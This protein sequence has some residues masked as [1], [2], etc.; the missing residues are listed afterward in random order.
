MNVGGFSG[1]RNKTSD[2]DRYKRYFFTTPVS[3]ANV[4]TM[5]KIL[6]QRSELQIAKYL[7]LYVLSSSYNVSRFELRNK[8]ETTHQWSLRVAHDIELNQ[9][10]VYHERLY[11]DNI[12]SEF[13]FERSFSS[14]HYS[15]VVTNFTSENVFQIRTKEGKTRSFICKVNLNF[16]RSSRHFTFDTVFAVIVSF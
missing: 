11:A 9:V 13:W 14:Q 5:K 8:T 4:N 12:V 1:H 2:N 16:L 10:R 3:Q 6:E 15:K 7:I